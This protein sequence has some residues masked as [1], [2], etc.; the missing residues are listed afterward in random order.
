MLRTKSP[1]NIKIHKLKVLKFKYTK[2]YNRCHVYRTQA[3]YTLFQ[4]P[5]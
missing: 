4:D 5:F 2:I 3:P 1:G